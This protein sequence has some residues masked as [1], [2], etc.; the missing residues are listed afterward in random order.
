MDLIDVVKVVIWSFGQ[1]RFWTDRKRHYNNKYIFI[2]IV[3][4]KH[5]SKMKMTKMTLTTLTTSVLYEPSLSI[6]FVENNVSVLA[7]SLYDYRCQVTG[8]RIGEAVRLDKH[9][10]SAVSM[11]CAR[12]TDSL[13]TDYFSK[14]FAPRHHTSYVVE[15]TTR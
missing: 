13:L 10:K 1:N 9:L 15:S 14:L 7:K 4:S 6:E 8:E 2:I 12:L 11:G 3:S 5:T